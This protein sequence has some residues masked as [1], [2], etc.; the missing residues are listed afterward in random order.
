MKNKIAIILIVLMMVSFISSNIAT[1]NNTDFQNYSLAVKYLKQQD[2]DRAKQYLDQIVLDSLPYS[3]YLAKAI[4]LKTILVTAEIKSDLM[5]K[6]Y[7]LEGTEKI[8]LEEENKRDEFK[9]KADSYE[10]EAK[11][12]VDT[13]L[14]LAN[15][16]LANL[17]PVEIETNKISNVGQPNA[18]VVDQIKSGSLPAEE[19]MN[20]LERD[21]T[22]KNINKYLE[23]TLGVKEFNN[24]FVIKAEQGDTLSEIAANYGLPVSLLIQVNDHIENPNLILP[25]EKVYV[26]RVNSSHINYP[27][28]FYYLSVA[29]Y[30]AN[31]E[32][33]QEINKLVASAYQLTDQKNNANIDYQEKSK[34]LAESMQ[35]TQ[36]KNRLQ[37]QT[38]KI[39]NQNRQLEQ[40]KEKYDK[41]MEQLNKLKKEQEEE[42]E[43]QESN[44]PLDLD[45][46]SNSDYNTD[47]DSL[48]Y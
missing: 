31:K 40:L 37:E 39:E 19:K 43:N 10:L 22:L 21:L 5:V 12:K 3:E 44:D 9:T 18:D 32:R 17:P 8:A 13:L 28:Y 23:Y 33:Q 41:L 47:E 26:P 6:D 7:I 27:S 1:A 11:R 38:E 14:G 48:T 15:Y 45:D 4:Y 46:N 34:E 2:L 24:L 25:G 29:S 35:N 16:L 30:E 42:E 36:Y 20:S